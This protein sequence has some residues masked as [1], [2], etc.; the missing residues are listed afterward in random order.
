MMNNTLNPYGNVNVNF[1]QPAVVES[2]TVY[3]G[4]AIEAVTISGTFEPAYSE[5]ASTTEYTDQEKIQAII[6]Y[7]VLKNEIDRL[8]A[9]LD[10]HKQVILDGLNLKEGTNTVQVGKHVL[11]IKQEMYRK[12]SYDQIFANRKNLSPAMVDALKFG[13]DLR[14]KEYDAL[15]EPERNYLDN[16]IT[17]NPASPQLEF[18]A[19]KNV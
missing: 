13:C 2:I 18:K 8:K 11:K 16:F 17:S 19:V 15:S 10:E 14:K 1:G 4:G 9:K 3:G 5:P 12:V 7:K 6:E